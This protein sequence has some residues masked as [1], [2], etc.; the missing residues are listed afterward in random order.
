MPRFIKFD[1]STKK[2]VVKRFQ[3]G[4]NWQVTA[5]ENG[6]PFSTVRSWV[7]KKK[8]DEAQDEA[9]EVVER[10]PRGGARLVKVNNERKNFLKQRIN[11]NLG[12]ILMEL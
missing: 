12:V 2:R 7:K 5:R 4:E 1:E 9:G 3:Q 11:E 8:V 10:R 6:I